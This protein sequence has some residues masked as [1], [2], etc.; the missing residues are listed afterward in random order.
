MQRT[1]VKRRMDAIEAA[2]PVRLP[3]VAIILQWPDGHCSHNGIDYADMAEA[4]D[5]LQPD[6]HIPVAVVDYSQPQHKAQG[7]Q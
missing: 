5:I 2:L 1:T 7:E 6:E 4:L 3:K